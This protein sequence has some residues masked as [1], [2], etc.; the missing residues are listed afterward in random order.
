M[1]IKNIVLHRID[2]ELKEKSSLTNSE[3]LMTIDETV[4]EFVEKLLKITRWVKLNDLNFDIINWSVKDKFID[5]L[6]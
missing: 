4:V 6:H 3:K 5:I 2:K 1:E